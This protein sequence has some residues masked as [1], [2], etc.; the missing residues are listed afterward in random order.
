MNCAEARTLL[1]AYA[2][3]ELGIERCLEFE[4][5]L[6][7]CPRCAAE[8]AS[9]RA[10]GAAL[11]DKLDYHSAPLALHRA[12]RNELARAAPA[13]A[14]SQ[15]PAVPRPLPRWTRMAASFILVAG[16]SSA[17]TYY[18]L[19]NGRDVIPDEVFASHVRGVQS[20]DRVVDVVSTDKHTVKP[21]LD[22]K[23]DFAAPVK[24]LAKDGFPLVGGRVDYIDGH[25]VAALVYQSGKHVITLFAWPNPTP[26]PA[27]PIA[28]SMHRGDSLAQ[29]SDG[30]M[31]YWA[32][33][34]VAAPE[35]M[36]F[37]ARFQVTE[38]MPDAPASSAPNRP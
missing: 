35:L 38:P 33:S 34:D 15:A 16:L 20:G 22:A 6:E 13:P 1:D 24:D 4:R 11:R 25:T 17:L 37:C 12:L 3:G 28:A 30:T 5:H 10:L 32:V 2:D 26:G 23:L 18:G 21:W 36:A 14:M 29:W 7:S 9:R 27:K 31:T 19:P 8:L